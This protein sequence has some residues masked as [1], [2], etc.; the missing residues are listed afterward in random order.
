[1]ST[2]TPPAISKKDINQLEKLILKIE[3]D[4]DNDQ[5]TKESLENYEA[6]RDKIWVKFGGSDATKNKDYY[7]F[8][9]FQSF[10]FG[11]HGQLDDAA[12]SVAVGAGYKPNDRSWVSDSAK[13]WA[14]NN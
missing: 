11:A 4:I 2:N 5:L 6:F 9:E 1:M 14:A 7:K 12:M 8:F 3:H 13:S 10:I